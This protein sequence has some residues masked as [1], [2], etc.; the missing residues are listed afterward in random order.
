MQKAVGELST[1]EFERLIERVVDRR[2][3]IW[4]TQLTDALVD[5]EEEDNTELRPEFTA[6][7]RRALQEARSGEGVDLKAFRDQVGS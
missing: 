7:L 3:H 6:S 5:L 1:E 4:L 2:L